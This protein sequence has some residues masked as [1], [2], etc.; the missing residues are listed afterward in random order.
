VVIDVSNSPSFEDE[1]ALR[2]F[3]TSTGNLLAAEAA[4]EP[5]TTSRY[6]S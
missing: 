4:R 3:E 1:A 2:F 6:R 5:V